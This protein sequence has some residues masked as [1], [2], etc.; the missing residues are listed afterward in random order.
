[1]EAG[2]KRAVAAG[3]A[4]VFAAVGG[5]ITNVVT[6]SPSWAWGTSLFLLVL[7]GTSTQ[8]YLSSGASSPARSVHAAGAGS[9][10]IGGSA[11]G[12]VSAHST[13]AAAGDAPPPPTGDAV[14][15]SGPGSVAVGGDALDAVTS[16]SGGTA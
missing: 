2:T 5:V 4:S 10:A 1:M 6:D 16:S 9:I 12:P 7:A 13:G 11:R 8:V 3:A 15:A 14:T